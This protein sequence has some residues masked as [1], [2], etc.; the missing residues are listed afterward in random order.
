MVCWSAGPLV[1]WRTCRLACSPGGL[2]VSWSAGLLV[3]WSA[4]LPPTRVFLRPRPSL[5]HVRK[6]R[7]SSATPPHAQ[8]G[9]PRAQSRQTGRPAHAV[10][11]AHAL[12]T[13]TCRVGVGHAAHGAHGMRPSRR[14]GGIALREERQTSRPADKESG[15]GQCVL[16]R[17]SVAWAC[18]SHYTARVWRGISLHAVSGRT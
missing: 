2:L 7:E 3:C 16:G 8:E 5:G 11:L 10:S 14:L 15:C 4:G 17:G 13:L 18:L 12:R 9:R 1:C 6:E